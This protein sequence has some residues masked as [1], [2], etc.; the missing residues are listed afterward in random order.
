[1]S[2]MQSS[3]SDEAKRRFAEEAYPN[4]AVDALATALQ[5]QH[6]N[7]AE[8]QQSI[9]DAQIALSASNFQDY[10]PLRHAVSD[11]LRRLL[12]PVSQGKY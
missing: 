2:D 3:L 4:D 9:L 6:P 12:S 1:M 11:A 7:D 5:E 10:G 8:L